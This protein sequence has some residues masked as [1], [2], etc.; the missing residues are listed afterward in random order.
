MTTERGA[1]ITASR[2]SGAGVIE[3]R[4]LTRS[5]GAT[6]AVRPLSVQIGPGGITGLLGPNGSGKTTFL[7]MLMGLVRP[8]AGEGRV[9]GVVLQGD[10]TAV[11]RCS[12]YMPGEVVVYGEMT[13]A[14]H[15]DWFLRG[16]DDE[17]LPRALTIAE[18][19]GLPLHRKVRGYSHGMKRQLF[20]AAALAPRVA[21]RVLDEPTEGLDPSKRG[22]VLQLLVEEAA[23]G[24]TI[25]LSSHHLGEVERICDRTL[26][27]KQG[28]LLDE[29]ESI[30]V[31]RR[32]RRVARLG[33]NVEGDGE[34]LTRR[35]TA[36]GAKEIRIE[37][38][39]ATFLLD[40]EDP[41]E[42]F[43]R[44]LLDDALPPPTSLAFGE[45]SLHELYRTLY[46]K[47]GI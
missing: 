8:D 7:R 35:L 40:E 1:A 15:L 10:G 34:E 12:S 21:V 36:L 14:A 23:R 3:V 13:G 42:S 46:G 24:V 29:G 26:F 27:L 6:L 25:L 28:E 31:R 44:I 2:P 47:E 37:D 45:F 22:E 17:V 41:R 30:A 20:F 11:R 43:A 18:G 39:Q 33:W 9:D 16:R 5:F 32:A 19:L 38:R 4:G